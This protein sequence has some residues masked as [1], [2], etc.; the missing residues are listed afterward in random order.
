MNIIIKGVVTAGKLLG[1]ISLVFPRRLEY[2]WHLFRRSIVTGRYKGSF[3][4]FGNNSLLAPDVTLLSASNITIGNGSSIMKHCVLETCPT[5]G[6]Q[7]EMIIG[8]GVSLGEYSHVTCANRV[9]IGDDVLTGRFVLITDNSHGKSSIDEIDIAPLLR[10]VTSNGPVVI[11]KKVW[12][13][14]K[15]TVLPGV[16]VGEGA[17]IAANAVV[18]KD[19]PAYSVVA[20][21]PAKVVKMIK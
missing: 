11:G 1:Y 14:D 9:V 20:G 13:G 16:T 10:D 19:V 6:I 5:A 4:A 21:C 17:I 2:L 8:N 12:I 3:K 18:T 7:P 15:V